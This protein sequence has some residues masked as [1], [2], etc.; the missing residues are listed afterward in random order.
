V[1]LAKMLVQLS[2]TSE[3]KDQKDALTVMEVTVQ[4][5][6]VGVTEVALD[7]N[8]TTDLLL[9]TTLLQLRLVK[10]LESANKARGSLLGKVDTTKLA[11]A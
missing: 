5:E 1:L 8:L 9:D 3:L 10:H 7:L 2:A 4:S 11:L 6:D